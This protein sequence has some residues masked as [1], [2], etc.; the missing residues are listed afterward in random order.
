MVL[1]KFVPYASSYQVLVRVRK[2]KLTEGKNK[3]V[4]NKLPVLLSL[5]YKLSFWKVQMRLFCSVENL[6]MHII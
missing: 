1:C 3:R 5:L 2:N 6:S 4:I